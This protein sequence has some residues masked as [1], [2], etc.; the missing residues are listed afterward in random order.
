M[1]KA[2]AE[3]NRQADAA[4]ASIRESPMVS[5]YV[6]ELYQLAVDIVDGID[7]ALALVPTPEPGSGFITVNHDVNRRLMQALGAAARA[8]ALCLERAKG[9]KQSPLEYKVH[10]RRAAWLRDLLEGIDLEPLED[11][12]VRN[13]LEHFD[14]YVDQA[15]IGAYS[16]EISMPALVPVDMVLSD[17][18]LLRQFAVGG[19]EPTTY[20]VRVYI[21]GEHRFIN[22]GHEVDIAALRVTAVGIRDRLGE[23]LG[24]RVEQEGSAILVLTAHSFSRPLD[25]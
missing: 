20:W 4:W 1:S 5:V 9:W 2:T 25:A 22:C 17:R 19:E 14:E 10:L 12:Q 6:I 13:T 18:H 8:R 3:L 11:A 24:E 15:A 23:V 7:A 21:S 16:G